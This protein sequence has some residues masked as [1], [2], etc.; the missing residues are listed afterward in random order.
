[1][2]KKISRKKRITALQIYQDLR[3][4]IMDFDL[5]PGTRVTETEIA[6]SFNV[7]RTPVREALQRLELEGL[8][9]IR[10]KQGCFVRPVDIQT[11][12]DYY[13][14]RVALEAAAIE[15]AC[16][17]MPDEQIEELLGIW[18]PKNCTMQFD[19]PGQIQ[20]VEEAF[21][22]AIA[23]GSG[24]TVLANYI[25]DV[26][27]H[28]RIIR[29]LGFPDEQSIRETYEEHYELCQLLIARESK[30]ATRDMIKHIRKS[31]GIARSV[32][33]NQLQQHRKRS[34]KRKG[35]KLLSFES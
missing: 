24:N 33:L 17:N 13:D 1:M 23:E 19:Y 10:P 11:I 20:E 31:Q 30:K 8:L 26:N 16:E 34:I 25:K 6:E 4:M 5:F 15:L 35:K 12:S 21:H 3:Q 32:T 7:S 9:T 18:N 28:I 22:V 2:R 29:R 27:D 14:V